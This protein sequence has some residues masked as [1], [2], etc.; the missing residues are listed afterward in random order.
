MY[1]TSVA[2]GHVCPVAGHHGLCLE[3]TVHRKVA[4]CGQCYSLCCPAL[5]SSE[6]AWYPCV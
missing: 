4:V 5:D 2:L 6:V 1:E 3:E